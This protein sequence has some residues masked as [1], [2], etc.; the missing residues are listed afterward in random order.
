MA[1]IV[2]VICKCKSSRHFCFPNTHLFHI[3]GKQEYQNLW[4]SNKNKINKTTLQHIHGKV[5]IFLYTH[6]QLLFT[7]IFS[8]LTYNIQLHTNGK[9]WSKCPKLI[10]KHLILFRHS[11][12]WGQCLNKSS[13]NSDYCNEIY[14]NHK[15]QN[16]YHSPLKIVVIQ[17]YYKIIMTTFFVE[18][19]LPSNIAP[20][21]IIWDTKLQ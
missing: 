7:L 13:T 2:H 6:F 15:M 21:W 16:S 14:L 8:I 17:Y 20:L 4:K 11:P 9:I 3:S 12:C 10:G 5:S 18:N 1:P 19:V